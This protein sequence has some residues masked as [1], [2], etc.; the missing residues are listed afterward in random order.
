MTMKMK[1]KS[2]ASGAAGVGYDLVGQAS[3]LLGGR[4][5]PARA[6]DDT[7]AKGSVDPIAAS[8][9]ALRAARSSL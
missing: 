3:R 5:T 7:R 9:T 6:P 2:G 4:A 8:R 1:M